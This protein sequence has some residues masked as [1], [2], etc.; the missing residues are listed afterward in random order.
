MSNYR[1]T[2]TANSPRAAERAREREISEME[3][4]SGTRN[5]AGAV[6]TKARGRMSEGSKRPEDIQ[7]ITTRPA[8]VWVEGKE[9]RMCSVRRERER[10][11]EKVKKKK[12]REEE[13]RRLHKDRSWR[14]PGAS[15][16]T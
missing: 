14:V 10:E 11:R 2:F 4:L 15:L 9:R 8:H 1:T 7:G 5:G 3:I 13:N 12:E 6:G 16:H